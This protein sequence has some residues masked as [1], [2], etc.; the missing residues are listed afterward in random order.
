MNPHRVRVVGECVVQVAAEL[1]RRLVH[2]AVAE[3]GEEGIAGVLLHDGP[4]AH[5]QS[6][7]RGGRHHVAPAGIDEHL[8][9]GGP[10]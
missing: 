9:R 5:G 6:L 4:L 10:R 8:R 1:G 3:A 7:C 2:Q